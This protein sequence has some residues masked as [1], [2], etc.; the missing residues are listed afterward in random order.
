MQQGCHRWREV[1]ESSLAAVLGVC[2]G[3]VSSCFHTPC[4]WLIKMAQTSA[5]I[6]P[7]LKSTKPSAIACADTSGFRHAE[8]LR[9]RLPPYASVVAAQ[10]LH[11]HAGYGSF[12][13]TWGMPG[14]VKTMLRPLITL[15]SYWLGHQALADNFLVWPCCGELPNTTRC[16]LHSTAAALPSFTQHNLRH[17][18]IHAH[19]AL[20]E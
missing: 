5:C 4:F 19:A 16:A 9:T 8:L 10:S 20:P 7:P 12:L 15:A 2:K 17:A 14:M 3:H 1:Q 11:W 18:H 13:T 6:G